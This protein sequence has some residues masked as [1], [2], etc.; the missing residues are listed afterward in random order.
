[1][2]FAIFLLEKY[3]LAISYSITD[4]FPVVTH[5]SFT[6]VRKKNTRIPT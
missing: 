6:F 5:L 2:P 4:Y 1:M 3:S